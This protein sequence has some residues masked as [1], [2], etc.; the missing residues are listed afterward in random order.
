MYIK[1]VNINLYLPSLILGMYN[2]ILL[3]YKKFPPK[4]FA[5]II[6]RG[7]EINK[8]VVLGNK[9]KRDYTSRGIFL[10]KNGV[11]LVSHCW[12]CL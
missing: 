5:D 6:I 11:I 1:N 3:L 2:V 12:I 7:S 4:K 8:K 9:R 10:N